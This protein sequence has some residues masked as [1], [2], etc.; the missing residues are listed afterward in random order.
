MWSALHDLGVVSEEHFFDSDLYDLFYRI[1]T[2]LVAELIGI[3][4]LC[5]HPSIDVVNGLRKLDERVHAQLQI[6]DN[7]VKR[8]LGVMIRD[9]CRHFRGREHVYPILISES[10]SPAI[11]ELL[12][13]NIDPGSREGALKFEAI[14]VEEWSNVKF[15]KNMVFQVADSQFDLIKDKATCPTRSNAVKVLLHGTKEG[16]RIPVTG[17]KVLLAFLLDP[18]YTESFKEYLNN[19]M[20]QNTW[21]DQVLEYLVIKL[22]AKELEEKE[23]GRFFGASPVEER[24]RRLVQLKNALSVMQLYMPEQLLTTGELE[25]IHKLVSFRHL[26]N[27]LP[28]YTMIHASVDF[29]KWNNN[30][31]R[32]TVDFASGKVLDEWFG[33]NGLYSR[34]MLAFEKMLVYYVDGSYQISWDGQSGGIEGLNQATWT[35]L[36]LAGLKESL[37]RMGFRYHITVKGDDVRITFLVPTADLDRKGFNVVRQEIMRELQSKCE[38]LGWELNPN[39]S[40]VSLSLVCTSK[41][42]LIGDTWLPA[43][44]KKMAKVEAISNVLYPIYED[45]VANMY[46]V[47]HSACSQTTAALPSY[48]LAMYMAIRLTER[49]FK[50]YKLTLE[51]ATALATWP[52]VLG[53][54]G[55]LPLQT[56]LVRGENDML[57]CS[58]SLLRFIVLGYLPYATDIELDI[59]RL[60][61]AFMGILTQKLE[62]EID[63]KQLCLDPYSIPLRT[64]VRPIQ[65][66]RRNIRESLKQHCR[67]PDVCQLLTVEADEFEETLLYNLES[68][69]PC[70]PRLLSAVWECTPSYL[71]DELITKFLQSKTVLQF[72]SRQGSSPL[73]QRKLPNLIRKVIAAVNARKLYWVGV[74]NANEPDFGGEIFGISCP[75]WSDKNICT[76]KI[77][78]HIREKSW[79]RQM[80]GITYP[81]LVDQLHIWIPG[82]KEGEVL[83]TNKSTFHKTLNSIFQVLEISQ[84]KNHI[85]KL[86][87]HVQD[88]HF[89]INSKSH[90]YMTSGSCHAW[91][92]SKTDSRVHF[93]DWPEEAVSSPALK[94]KKLIIILSATSKLAPE[95]VVM[96]QRLSRIISGVSIEHLMKMTCTDKDANFFT[97]VPTHDY[98]LVT[99]PNSRPNIANIVNVDYTDNSLLTM[100]SKSRTVNIAAVHYFLIAIS[101]FPL[102]SNQTLS[103]T[104]PDILY[105]CF[106]FEP[107]S[108]KSSLTFEFCNACCSI[109]DDIPI[110]CT[111]PLRSINSYDLMYLRA[112]QCTDG[113]NAMITRAAI[114]RINQ[115]L[116]EPS[117]LA[118][119]SQMWR[120][121]ANK[122]FQIVVARI[123]EYVTGIYQSAALAGLPPMTDNETVQAICSSM[124]IIP[125]VRQSVKTTILSKTDPGVTS[126]AVISDLAFEYFKIASNSS[127]LFYHNLEAP[128]ESGLRSMYSPIL[129]LLHR[130]NVLDKMVETF[131]LYAPNMLQIR[132]PRLTPLYTDMIAEQ[133]LK[134]FSQGTMHWLEKLR[135]EPFGRRIWDINSVAGF[136]ASLIHDTNILRLTLP[137]LLWSIIPADV[138]V[139]SMEWLSDVTTDFTIFSADVLPEECPNDAIQGIA[140]LNIILS[141]LI[142]DWPYIG[143]TDHRITSYINDSE[144]ILLMNHQTLAELGAK[145]LVDYTPGLDEEPILSIRGG[146]QRYYDNLNWTQL[147]L[148]TFLRILRHITYFQLYDSVQILEDMSYQLLS[149][150]AFLNTV[151]PLNATQNTIHQL[152]IRIQEEEPRHVQV[153]PLTA[154]QIPYLRETPPTAI[155][156]RLPT[157]IA[158]GACTPED[159]DIFLIGVRAGIDHILEVLPASKDIG[160]L[161]HGSQYQFSK[162]YS[163][164]NGQPPSIDRPNYLLV[165]YG[166]AS[167]WIARVALNL[168]QKLHVLNF[169]IDIDLETTSP[170]RLIGNRARHYPS[171]LA[172]L[173]EQEKSRLSVVHGIGGDICSATAGRIMCKT[174]LD[175]DL[176]LA[177]LYFDLTTIPVTDQIQAIKGVAN[178]IIN[179][180]WLTGP[181]WLLWDLRNINLMSFARSISWATEILIDIVCG[182]GLE[183]PVL[184][185]RLSMLVMPNLTGLL[186]QVPF[187]LRQSVLT[188]LDNNIFHEMSTP[189][190]YRPNLIQ[191][192]APLINPSIFHLIPNLNMSEVPASTCLCELRPIILDIIESTITKLEGELQ[193]K[194]NKQHINQDDYNYIAKLFR[195]VSR[196]IGVKTI[197]SYTSGEA[198]EALAISSMQRIFTNCFP[199]GTNHGG[200]YEVTDGRVLKW[201]QIGPISAE[202][203]AQRHYV[204]IK[205]R[206]F[207][208]NLWAELTRGYSLGVD[209]IS[210]WNLFCTYPVDRYDDLNLMLNRHLEGLEVDIC[211]TRNLRLA[212]KLEQL[213]VKLKMECFKGGLGIS[214]GV[215]IRGDRTPLRSPGQALEGSPA[216]NPLSPDY[217]AMTPGRQIRSVVISLYMCNAPHTYI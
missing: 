11:S 138:W 5:G 30:F 168:Y 198:F 65:L 108:L 25:T 174:V 216:Y 145:Q 82:D 179:L 31:R 131:N 116:L 14:T 210:L 153:P 135:N 200:S 154:M 120:C 75:M 96:L 89:E 206:A 110:T 69:S 182:Y 185:L 42:Y 10:L 2:P 55:P 188:L 167:G 186:T 78:A 187:A 158:D 123:R 90:H 173:T 94:L 26:A 149:S 79:R 197:V 35:F 201:S 211:C 53:G 177:Q 215:L 28:G 112:V 67:H 133:I 166:D 193:T 107:D 34:T 144:T 139:A 101:M 142:F 6:D 175:T 20:T 100:D 209:L 98:S 128:D 194:L 54:P 137:K 86:S 80:Y 121:S 21:D 41:Q 146:I 97:R 52:Q 126:I 136:R 147:Q 59:D 23:L 157:P 172:L 134:S 204:V 66:V 113:E 84:P 207:Q 36:F 155:L 181:V 111:K 76:T 43:S 46:S 143:Y 170:R 9:L 203:T 39:E 213:I 118:S 122:A 15:G 169:A 93:P 165:V 40:Y 109:I 63:L 70:C 7:T 12:R 37:E 50:D 162:A 91:M 68:L 160:L 77:T 180:N 130:E 178:Q 102:Q 47:A 129:S 19:Y 104:H 161:S 57:S 205:S 114:T 195:R 127:Q 24:G 212:H 148:N 117:T 16:R 44:M 29:S 73:V 85:I 163:L 191:D 119:V 61:K 103:S 74:L 18:N 17:K 32:Q 56:F 48:V 176:T 151:N 141:I 190:N 150:A 171:E 196:L 189:Y 106:D 199:P 81:S 58:L 132:I 99:M 51:R 164:L 8:S 156:H 71:V 152:I 13:Q 88:A 217:A 38:K 92:G 49:E 1:E 214:L 62:D 45:Y 124:G 183:A 95:I 33:L 115:K 208:I 105:A 83:I 64:P 22:T 184:V 202:I 3:V 60:K 159:L 27:Q 140:A 87:N 4:K 192:L 125:Q 72:L